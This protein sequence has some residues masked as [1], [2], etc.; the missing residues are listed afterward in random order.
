MSAEKA[1]GEM[2]DVESHVG[3]KKRDSQPKSDR[4][5]LSPPPS[6]PPQLGDRAGV[7]IRWMSRLNHSEDVHAILKKVKP[8]SRTLW[9]RFTSELLAAAAA[10]K[11]LPCQT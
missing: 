6:T 1:L 8:K 10:P 7:M 4:R 11:R 5:P 3:D 9:R 2:S